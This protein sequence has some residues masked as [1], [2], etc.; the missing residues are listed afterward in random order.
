[1]VYGERASLIL[2]C[3]NC[4][5]TYWPEQLWHACMVCITKLRGECNGKTIGGKIGGQGV[6][7]SQIL[8]SFR[9]SECPIMIIV[10]STR[11]VC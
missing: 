11:P 1:M 4:L 10:I 7:L 8:L 5:K 9:R 3:C 2:L 6:L